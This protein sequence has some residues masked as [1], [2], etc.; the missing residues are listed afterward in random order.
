MNLTLTHHVVT[1][2]HFMRTCYLRVPHMINYRFQCTCN[3]T[4]E[5]NCAQLQELWGMNLTLTHHVVTSIHF[6]RTC[7]LRVPHMINYRFQCT[8]NSTVESNCAQL[9]ELWGMNLTL[10]H[11]VVT[12]VHFMRTCYLR[13]PHMINYRFKCTCNSTVES[14]CAQLQELWGM[15]LTLTH[16]VVTSVHFDENMLWW[17]SSRD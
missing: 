1:S 7:Y 15:N 10:T 3:S 12:Y 16:H 17:S 4:V 2:V 9:Q 11:H 6:M 14:N 5:R 13:V 8:C